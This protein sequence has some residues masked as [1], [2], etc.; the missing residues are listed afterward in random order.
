MVKLYTDK[1]PKE[2][3]SLD[4]ASCWSPVLGF[5]NLWPHLQASAMCTHM[6]TY[7]SRSPALTTPLPCRD[8]GADMW[9]LQI[10]CSAF[11]THQDFCPSSSS[12]SPLMKTTGPNSMSPAQFGPPATAWAMLTWTT[13]IRKPVWMGGEH[14]LASQ[15][16]TMVSTRSC[17]KHMENSRIKLMHQSGQLNQ[18]PILPLLPKTF[19]FLHEIPGS[20]LHLHSFLRRFPEPI[21]I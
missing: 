4:I 2:P 1:I 7:R 3:S 6:H 13:E 15:M 11:G 17:R 18:K 20:K 9:G 12:F 19:F 10:W 21:V 16:G 14:L 8:M 5:P